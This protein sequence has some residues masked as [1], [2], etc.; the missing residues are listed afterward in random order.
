MREEGS[1]AGLWEVDQHATGHL[2]RENARVLN[3]RV[4]IH[5][6]DKNS[7]EN[8]P[9]LRRKWLR[10][11][12]PKA[13]AEVGICLWGEGM[14]RGG[15]LMP[16]P[17]LVFLGGVDTLTMLLQGRGWILSRKWK[18][19]KVCRCREAGVDRLW[20]VIWAGAELPNTAP[21]GMSIVRLCCSKTTPPRGFK[22]W[23]CT[24]TKGVPRVGGEGAQ[25]LS[26]HTEKNLIAV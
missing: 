20:S 19:E 25:A 10:G 24:K 2:G 6:W 8:K 9:G 7:C 16:E 5:S 23:R 3:S 14:R 26:F 13:E 17:F 18:E 21:R 12:A 22:G 1:Q 15:G 4:E 11:S